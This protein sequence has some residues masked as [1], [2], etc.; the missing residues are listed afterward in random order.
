[1][2]VKPVTTFEGATGFA[3]SPK[4]EL[5]LRATT[6]FAGQDAFYEKAENA[7]ARAV[8]LARDLAVTDWGWLS[9]FLVWL[10][11][12]GNIRTM[13]TILA[14]EGVRAR[15]AAKEDVKLLIDV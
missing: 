9:P 4:S 10:R 1:M 3:R 11:A 15:V 2:V 5:Y 6:M 14:V 12:E 7:D 8:E 13:A